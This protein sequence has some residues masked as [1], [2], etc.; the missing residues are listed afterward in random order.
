MKNIL[1]ICFYYLAFQNMQAQNVGINS[2][3]ATPNTSAILDVSAID[4]GLLIPRVN[5]ISVTDA[6]TI[7]TPANSLMVYN[8]NGNTL[9]MPDSIGYYYN[10]GTPI[11]PNWVKLYTKF[12]QNPDADWYKTGTTTAP[13]SIND[14]MFHMG[15]T[16][17]GTNNPSTPF[18]VENAINDT[19]AKFINTINSSNSIGVS[20]SVIN[21]IGLGNSINTNTNANV[22]YAMLNTIRGAGTSLQF[23]VFN[24]ITSSGDGQNTGTINQLTGSGK[25][26]HIGSNNNLGGVGIGAQFGILNYINNSGNNEHYGVLNDLNGNG[27]GIHYAIVNTLSG[28]G[29]GN[30]YS[31]KNQNFNSGNGFHFGTYDSLSGK[32]TGPHFGKYTTLTGTGTGTQYGNYTK[33]DNW[34]DGTQFA[35]Y[36]NIRNVGNGTHTG[37]FNDIGGGDGVKQGVYNLLYQSSNSDIFGVRN[38]LSSQGLNTAYGN[39]SKISGYGDGNQYTTYNVIENTGD[40]NHYGTY[41]FMYGTGS[42]KK[43]GSY[44]SIPVVTGGNQSIGGNAFGVFSSAL[45]TAN[46]YAGFFRGKLSVGMDYNNNYIFPTTRGTDKQ[47]MV[48]DENG[49]VNWSNARS[50]IDTVAWL[51]TGNSGTIP[52]TN[53]LGTTDNKALRFRINNLWAGELDSTTRSV[54]FGLGAA[55][56]SNITAFGNVIIGNAALK[57]NTTGY[58]NVII[59]D[60]AG[61]N[62]NLYESV[63]IGNLAGRG[64]T[65]TIG[66]Y[67]VV[68]GSH[69]GDSSLAIASTIIGNYAGRK[70]QADGNVMIG[71]SAGRFNTT[72]ISTFVGDNAGANNTTGTGNSF[73]GYRS[74][75]RNEIGKF[76]TAVG[77]ESMNANTN[78][79]GNVAL[80]YR[81]LALQKFTNLGAEYQTYNIAIGN[82]TLYNNNPTNTTNGIFNVAIGDG[83][84]YTNSTGARNTAVGSRSLYVNTIGTWNTALGV[85]ALNSN[86]IADDNVA[87]GGE[88]LFK[89]TTSTKNVAVG[90]QALYTQSYNNSGAVYEGS[91]TA[92]GYQALY[93]NNSTATNNGINNVAV[94][95][96]SFRSNTTGLENTGL[97][98]NSG[99]FATGS[100]NTFVGNNAGYGIS[101]VISTGGANTSIGNRSMQQNRSGYQNTA[102]GDFASHNNSDGFQNTSLGA[103]ALDGNTTGDRNTSIGMW[104]GRTASVI[105]TGNDNTYLGY[106]SG[107]SNYTGSNNTLLGS[108]SN[109]VTTTLNYATAI[110]SGATV[111]CSN[112]LTL[113]GNATANRTKVGINFNTPISDIDINQSGGAGINQATGGINLRNGIFNWRIYNSSPY[114]RYNYSADGGATYTPMAYVNSVDG[115]WNAVSDERMKKDI[116]PIGIVLEKVLK[117]NPVT[118]FY[119]HNTPKDNKSIG[120]LAQEVAKL[121]PSI[122]SK[123]EDGDL[124]GINYAG[125]SVVAIKAIQEQQKIIEALTKRIELLESKVAK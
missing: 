110:G 15:Y 46:D 112:C 7:A 51:I 45:D 29:V 20:S 21:P 96:S 48:T 74:G 113:G 65:N 9:Q 22:G 72:G 34:A 32:G 58:N 85:D 64:Y 8:M 2:T 88:A 63:I 11:A 69:A 16:G 87:V 55:E 124:L 17:I 6:I 66:N 122:V 35:N 19:T 39:F 101:A 81:A 41:N 103:G 25:G 102:V 10:A 54:K 109:V 56:N 105:S 4:K 26:I 98:A 99:F 107:S 31:I 94:G 61:Y 68:I 104:S 121:F 70:N 71:N 60:S 78:A 47:I 40:G 43:Y 106:G 5:L 53:F 1:I 57:T 73:I 97:G 115:S 117:L 86:T 82:Y 91:N 14:T 90:R 30:Q 89:N 108:N 27:S 49:N 100:S 95:T 116:I 52:T 123:E 67:S 38:D 79:T 75:F 24:N 93:L 80:G 92:I 59:G 76:N 111:N 119:K 42:G 37:V 118:Y 33:I 13:T 114:V 50:T 44:D 83:T 23:G 3:G 77:G 36:N 84:L 120:F 125:M 62:K 28:N 18:H 12:N